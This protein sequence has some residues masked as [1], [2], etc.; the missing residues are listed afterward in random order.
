MEEVIFF[1]K[2][3]PFFVYEEKEEEKQSSKAKE[4]ATAPGKV[5][6]TKVLI[7]DQALEK[8]QQKIVREQEEKRKEQ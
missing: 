1:F 5:P 8:T 2:K 3:S 6:T 7:V 4:R